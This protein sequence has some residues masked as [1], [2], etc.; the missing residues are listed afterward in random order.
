MHMETLRTVLLVVHIGVGIVSLIA[1]WIPAFSKKGSRLHKVAGLW[2]VRSMALVL[3]SAGLLSVVMFILGNWEAAVFLGF[4]TLLTAQALWS[5]YQVLKT[6][7]R[8]GRFRTVQLFFN[9]AITLSGVGLI[10]IWFRTPNVLFIIF[11]LL[12]LI[13]GGMG[14]V[15]RWRATDQSPRIYEHLNGMIFSGGA[16]YT[17]FLAFG[18]QSLLPVISRSDWAFIPW[19]LPTLLAGIAVT[20]LAKKYRPKRAS[21]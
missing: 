21:T 3:L 9:T 15:S 10:A 6:R 2:Y 7:D 11:G 13:V 17:A 19:V 1:F 8:I 5:G 20:L 18:A 16:A 4:L 12:G 14:V